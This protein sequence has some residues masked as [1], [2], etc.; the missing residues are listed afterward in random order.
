M[1]ILDLLDLTVILVTQDLR[2]IK[3][4][5]VTLAREDILDHKVT[6]VA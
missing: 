5:L 6:M 2:V 3:E 4:S 1:D